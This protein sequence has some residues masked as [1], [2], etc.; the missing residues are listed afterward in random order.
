MQQPA[1][2]Q[3]VNQLNLTLEAKTVKTAEGRNDTNVSRVVGKVK[4]KAQKY[5]KTRSQTKA[6]RTGSG[7]G[8]G[9]PRQPVPC[10]AAGEARNCWSTEGGGSCPSTGSGAGRGSCMDFSKA[11][12]AGSGHWAEPGPLAL[13]HVPRGGRGMFEGTSTLNPPTDEI[14]MHQTLSLPERPPLTFHLEAA[15]THE[16]PGVPPGRFL[17]PPF[18]CNAPLATCATAGEEA[19]SASTERLLLNAKELI[20]R[21]LELRSLVRFTAVQSAGLPGQ[22][23]AAL[24]GGK[25]MGVKNVHH[26]EPWC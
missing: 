1:K 2:P 17:L 24:Q 14:C 15:S 3:G 5:G 25:S 9:G 20:Y 26:M 23:Q 7:Q 19:P 21:P 4:R 22:C 8:R 6:R 11:S 16:A 12:S 13:H 18:P 10:Y